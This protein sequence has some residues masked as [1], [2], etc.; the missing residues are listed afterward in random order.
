MGIDKTVPIEADAMIDHVIDVVKTESDR[1]RIATLGTAPIT[2]E[3]DAAFGMT[4][5]SDF[6]NSHPFVVDES[7]V[8]GVLDIMGMF[9]QYMLY[10]LTVVNVCSDCQTEIAIEEAKNVKAH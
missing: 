2:V 5:M 1:I 3:N 7:G 8:K 10:R 4:I 9:R 6:I